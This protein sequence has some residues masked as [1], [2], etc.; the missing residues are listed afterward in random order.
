MD[1]KAEEPTE[2]YPI[3][4]F[5]VDEFQEVLH[6]LI[7]SEE[8]ELV[9]VKLMATM[10]ED[11]STSLHLAAMVRNIIASDALIT[12]INNREE[13][14]NNKAPSMNYELIPS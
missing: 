2:S 12:Y 5:A 3:I 7:L 13:G 8:G 11:S 9:C 4:F 14:H 1:K 6:D 10:P